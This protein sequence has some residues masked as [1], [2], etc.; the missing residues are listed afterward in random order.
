MSPPAKRFRYGDAFTRT[1]HYTAYSGDVTLA[2]ANNPNGA[3]LGGTLTATAANGVAT[4]SALT[5]DKPGSGLHAHGHQRHLDRD[6]RFLRC[7]ESTDRLDHRV[8]QPGGHRLRH[9]LEQR[10][11]GRHGQRA[12]NLRLHACRRDGAACR[13]RPDALGD[14]H[15]DRHDRLH[16]GHQDRVD[17]RRS[18][19]ADDHLVQPGGHHL[20]H[21]LGQH[22]TRRHGQRAGN[23]RLHACQRDGASRRQRPDA[24]GD[25]H[26]DRHDRLHHGDRERIDQ[27]RAG[28]ADDHLVQPGGHHLRHGLGQHATGRHGQR[29]GD[30]RLHACQRDG[31]ACRQR[32]DPLGDLHADRHDRLHHGDRERVD[33]RRAGHADD[34]LVQPG[35]HHLRHG[36][37]QHATG[38]H[39]QRAGHLRLHARQRDGAAR[40]QRPDALG[41][42]SR[43]PTRPTTPRRRTSVSINVEQATPTITWSNPADITYGTALG[44]TQL[45][46]TASV[47][48]TFAYTPAS[49]T[50]LH[51]GNS[52]TLSVTFTPTDTIDYTTATKS[53]SINVEQATPTITWST[54]ADIIYGTA[55]GSTQLDATAS[56]PGTF[57]YTPASGTV[58]HAGNGQTLSVTF[59]PTTRS[60]TPRRPPSVSI[61]VDDVRNRVFFD[62]T[63][64]TVVV[65][66]T[67]AADTIVLAPAGNGAKATLQVTLNKKLISKTILLS[68][69]QQIR[70]LGQEGN[71]TITLAPEHPVSLKALRRYLTNLTVPVT[72]DGGTGTDKLIVNGRAAA[73]TFSL[74]AATL[75][76]NGVVDN[77]SNIENLAVNGAAAADTFVVAGLPAFPV[78]FT[79]GGGRDKLQGPDVANTWALTN[80]TKGTLDGT[81]SFVNFTNLTGGGD[82]DTFTLSPGVN[83]PGK[84]DGG[85]GAVNTINYANY[86]AAVT[87]N[88]Q[89][90]AATGTAGFANIQSFVGGAKV[91]TLVGANQTNQWNV[92]G[93]NA[94][95]VNG[96]AFTGFENL[97]GGTRTDT[98]HVADGASVAGNVDGGKGTNAIDYSGDGLVNNV[99]LQKNTATGMASFL[100]IQQ[101]VGA[102]INTTLIGLN[103][104]STWNVTGNNAGKV[105]TTTFSGV[106]NLTGG[107]GA[108]TFVLSDGAVV[109]GKI[110]GGGGANVLSYA[111][112]TT[113]ITVDLT[114]MSATN[115]GSISNVSSFVGGMS[116]SDTLVG[117]NRANVWTIS[118][119]N[120]GT[121]N[122]AAFSKFEN[123]T[124]GAE[125]RLRVCK[126]DGSFGPYRRRRRAQSAR[127]QRLYDVGRCRSCG[128]NR[129]RYGGHCQHSGRRR[130]F[131][132]RYAYRKRPGQRLGGRRREQHADRW[133]CTRLVVRRRR[134]GHDFGWRRGRSDRQR[135]G[136]IRHKLG[137]ARRLACLLGWIARLCNT[138]AATR[139]RH[140]RRQGIAETQFVN[141]YQRQICRQPHGWRRRR[142]V[143]RQDDGPRRQSVRSQGRGSRQLSEGLP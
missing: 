113:P 136:N 72:V 49:G 15:A 24:L 73:N 67:S 52:Q 26:A 65:G 60:T 18:G 100:N 88:L 99:N 30:V 91:D 130:R 16:H 31:A 27:R 138:H 3:T 114:A 121:V 70:V 117:P 87:V 78:T 93:R 28:H 22:A 12:G 102:G 42:P 105:G 9:G 85:G 11:T 1:Q 80:S 32:P 81:L 54:P 134:S 50:V 43:R 120:A 132:Q 131:G 37:G 51:A 34:H 109:S 25:L 6:V 111:R 104:A 141:N 71:D 58:L 4:F 38:R 116:A 63:T 36:L 89:T 47:P 110:N 33:Q 7:D 69:I 119:N 84:I 29:A 13:Q 142:L 135:Q 19:H 83:W 123:L 107:T 125:R 77:F 14:L 96:T 95:A 101:I 115:V 126:E 137:R 82:I 68:S 79:G 86:R 5:L 129:H 66:G 94:G 17:Q 39:G 8:V 140:D 76:V 59:T 41:R 21:G 128:R 143:L 57:A 108:D 10:A 122:T 46:A 23:V 20:R 112:C 139:C 92:T 133:I 55:L 61:N 35:G 124:G 45:D 98:F 2:L 44:S 64:G 53:V 127:L 48:G 90:L 75:T 56:V 106:G 40:R 74:D 103:S 97:T 118:A 62:A